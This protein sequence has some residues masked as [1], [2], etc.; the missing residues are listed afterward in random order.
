MVL[1]LDTGILL[2]LIDAADPLHEMV[3]RAVGILIGRQE[4]LLIASRPAANNGLGLSPSDVA[5]L[6]AETLAPICATVGETDSTPF[7]LL[8]LLSQYNVVGKQVHD[9]RLVAVMLSWQINAVLTLNER[10]FRRFEAEGI[11]I[12]TPSSVISSP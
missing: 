11:T 7:E 8:G 1:L 6:Y 2:R 10:N 3:E 4:D 9:A 5:A 12:V